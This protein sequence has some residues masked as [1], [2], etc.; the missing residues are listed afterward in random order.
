MC[1]H[2]RGRLATAAATSGAGFTTR[3]WGVAGPSS[4]GVVV[5]TRTASSIAWP[6]SRNVKVRIRPLKR[7]PKKGLSR[8]IKWNKTIN[9][10][11]I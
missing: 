6:V 10:T 7:L 3:G 8:V 4:M 11:F 1:A 2:F 5:A 9:L